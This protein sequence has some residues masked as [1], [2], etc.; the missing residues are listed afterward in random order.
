[1]DKKI[2][3]FVIRCHSCKDQWEADKVE[4]ECPACG[5]LCTEIVDTYIKV[6]PVFRIRSRVRLVRGEGDE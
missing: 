6:L 1:M 2:K 3:I 5:S 4:S